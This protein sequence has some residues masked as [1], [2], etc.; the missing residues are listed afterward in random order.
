M[1]EKLLQDMAS[2]PIGGVKEQHDES[3]RNLI[4]VAK[5]SRG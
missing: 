2:S 1:M 5:V 3:M 4:V